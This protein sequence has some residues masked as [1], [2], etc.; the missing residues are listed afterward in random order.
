MIGSKLQ[1]RNQWHLPGS[2]SLALLVLLPRVVAAMMQDV[3]VQS[4]V[5]SNA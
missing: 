2:G 4:N 1:L 5:I 3:V